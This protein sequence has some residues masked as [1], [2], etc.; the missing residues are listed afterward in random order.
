VPSRSKKE[1]SDQVARKRKAT[2]IVTLSLRIR[3][4]LR[5]QLE[6]AAK[7]H[8]QSLNA[9]IVSR[10]E[11]SRTA[12]LQQNLAVL[13]RE[14]IGEAFKATTKEVAEEVAKKVVG[15]V[16]QKLGEQGK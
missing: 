2:E 9:E 1:E 8:R 14:K 10:L 3:E 13:M 11:A 15:I 12:N 5:R 16:Q 4:E 6:D 7:V